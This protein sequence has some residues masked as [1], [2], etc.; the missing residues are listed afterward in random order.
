[1]INYQALITDL[2][3]IGLSFFTGV[4]DSLLNDFCLALEVSCG[5]NNIIAAN[6]GN[7]IGIAAG[8]YLATGHIPVVYMQNSGIGNAMNPLISLTHRNVYS[9]PMILVIGW[10]G[11]PEINDHAQHKKQG[12]LTTVLMNDMDIP[13][14]ILYNENTVLDNFK[15]AAAEATHL[16][17]P[18][19]L[20]V[21]KGIL[22]KAKKENPYPDEGEMMNREDAMDAVFDQMPDDTVYY[23]TTGRATRELHEMFVKR[24]LQPNREFLNVGS[25]GHNSS[26][27]LGMAMALPERHHVVFD[28]DAAT[29]MHLGAMPIIGKAHP[30]RFM[31]IVLNNG[32]HESVGGQISAGFNANLTEIAKGSG[33]ITCNRCIEDPQELKA[34]VA[35]LKDAD[36]PVFIEVKIRKG[37]R[38]RIPGLKIDLMQARKD[39]MN[40]VRNS[41]D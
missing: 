32:V 7:A 20:I 11:D 4:P 36:G 41:N 14:R 30:K 38:S 1:M 21:K 26:V 18:V 12:E 9:I 25:M 13:Y 28:G 24:D 17:T 10:R 16:E 19:A 8:H 2:K 37:I 27:A 33:Y 22:S 40:I 6:E 5:K 3:A 31:H 35:A 29:L 39:L 23:A 15:W 34:T